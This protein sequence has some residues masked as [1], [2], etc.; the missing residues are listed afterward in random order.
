MTAI[1]RKLIFFAFTV[2]LCSCSKLPMKDFLGEWTVE[3]VEAHSIT[4]NNDRLVSTQAASPCFFVGEQMEFTKTKIIPCPT[5]TINLREYPDF[6]GTFDY[7]YDSKGSCITIP[8]VSY[9]LVTHDSNT[10]LDSAS[11]FTMYEMKYLIKL[12]DNST[13]FLSGVRYEYDNLGNAVLS[14]KADVVLKR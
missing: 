12:H 11:S 9:L 5:S 6:P 3:Q 2:G 10:G 8:E 14:Y 7:S 13:L 4:S 1:F